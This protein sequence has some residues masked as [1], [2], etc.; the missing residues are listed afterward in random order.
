MD[1]GKWISN[2]L[3]DM[4]EAVHGNERGVVCFFLLGLVIGLLVGVGV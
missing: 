2:R 1:Y 3:D 4:A